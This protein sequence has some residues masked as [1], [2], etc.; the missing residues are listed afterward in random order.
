MTPDEKA[1]WQK[2]RAECIDTLDRHAHEVESV[3]QGG[4]IVCA[5]CGSVVPRKEAYG[6][7]HCS[8]C[9]KVMTA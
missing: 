3:K 2:R 4:S 1:A 7:S 5:K 9:Q 6:T 8:W